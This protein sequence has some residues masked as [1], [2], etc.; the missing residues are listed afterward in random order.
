M[1]KKLSRRI[2]TCFSVSRNILGVGRAAYFPTLPEGLK[3]VSNSAAIV[4][5]GI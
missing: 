3:I 1:G 2:S 4:G 5:Q